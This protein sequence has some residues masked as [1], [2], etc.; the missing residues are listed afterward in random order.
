[1]VYR[2]LSYKSV[3]AKMESDPYQVGGDPYQI[4]WLVVTFTKNGCPLKVTEW[5]SRL[6]AN[7]SEGQFHL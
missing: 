7:I 3:L 5:S 4:Y 1:M 2:L 6:N